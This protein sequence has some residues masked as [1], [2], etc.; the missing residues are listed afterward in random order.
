MATI[1]GWCSPLLFN[2]FSKLKWCPQA[3]NGWGP[4]IC[5]GV[6]LCDL[7][8]TCANFE[9]ITLLDFFLSLYL[10][11]G[12]KTSA[13]SLCQIVASITL[14]CQLTELIPPTIAWLARNHNPLWHL[15]EVLCQTLCVCIRHCCSPTP[16]KEHKHGLSLISHPPTR[17]HAAFCSG[18]QFVPFS[19]F[20]VIRTI[21][22]LS[23]LFSPICCAFHVIFQYI[24]RERKKVAISPPPLIK[25]GK[26]S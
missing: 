18:Y 24:R 14:M 2:S 22:Y 3:Q 21:N 10:A 16:P 25:G 11:H 7:Q 13:T 8:K 23:L 20:L 19:L 1:L 15:S 17:K 12:L 9:D 26:T 4:Q 5:C 6:L